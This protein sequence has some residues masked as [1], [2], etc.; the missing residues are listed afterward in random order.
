MKESVGVESKKSAVASPTKRIVWNPIFEFERN[1]KLSIPKVGEAIASK[2]RST[3]TFSE[4]L[5]PHWSVYLR[6]FCSLHLVQVYKKFRYL[7]VCQN[8][9]LYH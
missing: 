5:T 8:K 1:E 2:P 7:Q 9:K 3:P 4:K 6:S